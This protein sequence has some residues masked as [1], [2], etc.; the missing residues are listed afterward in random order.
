ML[1]RLIADTA[2]VV[3]LAFLAYVA[4]GGFLAWRLPRM[5]W[6]HVACA[7]Y[8]LGIT[9]IGW[10]CPLTH[11]ENWGRQK[12]GQTGLP[13][14]GFIDHYV[15]GIVYPEDHLLT[16]QLAV[17]ATVAVSWAGYLALTGRRRR[18]K[19]PSST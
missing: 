8:G 17:A 15:T 7:L 1:Y 19:T 12:A 16:A 3:H 13:E 14:A 18:N 6:P 11:L 9:V 4:L 5:I 10:N 2:M